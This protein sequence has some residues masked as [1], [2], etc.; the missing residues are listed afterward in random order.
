MLRCLRSSAS[1]GVPVLIQDKRSAD[2]FVLVTRKRRRIWQWQIY[3]RPLTGIRLSGSGF[4][5]EFAAR[6][7]GEKALQA[8]VSRTSER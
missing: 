7:A 5:T 8:L 6:L 1:V 2:Y 4:K 3:R